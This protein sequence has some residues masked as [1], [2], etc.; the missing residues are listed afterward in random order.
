RL[1]ETATGA[2]RGCFVGHEGQVLGLVFSQ[3]GRV[4][5]SSGVDRTVL[6]WDMTGRAG[7]PHRHLSA[8]RVQ[9]L[10]KELYG[11]DGAGAYRAMWA[12]AA[13]P[14]QSVP[15]LR[16]QLPPVVE[17]DAG[18][19][20]RLVAD[21]D[22]KRFATRKRAAQAL[23]QAG[24]GAEPGLRR[25]LQARLSLEVRQRIEVLLRE[26]QAANQRCD[27]RA[28][29]VLEHCNTPSAH[30]LLERLA[31]GARG[32]WRTEEAHTILER[33]ERRRERN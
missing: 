26:L 17:T 12:L 20:T 32:A 11:T 6:L 18:L 22:S 21:L 16:R 28:L 4:L 5:A 23:R 29:E 31:R 24:A 1:W 9:A 27:N 10:E 7:Q 13:A 8:G 3:D 15:W 30:R 14:E 2:E 19:I 33:L 25:A